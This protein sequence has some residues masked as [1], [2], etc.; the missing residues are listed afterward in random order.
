MSRSSLALRIAKRVAKKNDMSVWGVTGHSVLDALFQR[1]RENYK[2]THL[3]RV[4]SDNDGGYLLPDVF[5]DVS[6]CFSPGVSDTANFEHEIS[7]AHGIISF[8][9]DASVSDA[10]L[11]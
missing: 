2:S 11:K 10:P 6:H 3:I 7:E 5:A 9:A 4:G 1:I 8:M